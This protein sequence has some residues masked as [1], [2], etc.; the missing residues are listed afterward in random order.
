MKD[1]GQI[2]DECSEIANQRGESY[3]T[4]QEN[5]KRWREIHKTMFWVD[6]DEVTLA[7]IMISWKF[8][9]ERQKHKEDNSIDAINYIAIREHLIRSNLP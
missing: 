4:S 8:A 9:R 3:G 6:L 5:F 1:Y 2:L 7:E